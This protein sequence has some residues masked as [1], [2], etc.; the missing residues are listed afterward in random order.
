MGRWTCNIEMTLETEWI[1]CRSNAHGQTE[2][3]S[4]DD[5]EE[6]NRWNLRKCSAAGLDVLSTVFADELLPIVTP[7]VQQRLQ[8]CWFPCCTVADL[9]TTADFS[10]F[11]SSDMHL[12]NAR[13]SWS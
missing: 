4:E 5:G 3:D 8:V 6:V 12:Q 10:S 1:W 11:L 9:T 13:F 2:N 7:I